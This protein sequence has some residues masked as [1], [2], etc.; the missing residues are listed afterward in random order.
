VLSV[1]ILPITL[2]LLKFRLIKKY[3]S[4][5]LYVLSSFIFE[6]TSY[7]FFINGVD[8]QL[9]FNLYGLSE[10][11]CLI[12]FFFSFFPDK[13]KII[14]VLSFIFLT[15]YFYNFSM[16]AEMDISITIGSTIW[17]ILSL[18][19]LFTI[20]KNS[21]KDNL[22]YFFTIAIL[23]YNSGSIFLFSIKS[24]LINLDIYLWLLH[25]FYNALSLLIIS[26]A[27]WKLPTNDFFKSEPPKV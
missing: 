6:I 25:N 23:I 9:I 13:K 2:F 27:I 24:L 20:L 3:F 14:T 4:I 10:F 17:I 19:C 15:T 26:F 21:L 12:Y 7:A 5:F 1:E 11:F 22:V 18:I 16:S 8:N